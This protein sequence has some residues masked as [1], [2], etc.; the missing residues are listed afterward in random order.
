MYREAL[1]GLSERLIRL[2]HVEETNVR[3]L[4]DRLSALSHEQVRQ[5]LN[6]VAHWYAARINELHGACH[7]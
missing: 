1:P 7:A 3:N 4:R 6:D 5:R 2:V